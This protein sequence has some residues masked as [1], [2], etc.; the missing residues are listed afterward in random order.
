MTT[1]QITK[2]TKDIKKCSVTYCDIL[3]K[4]NS[5]KKN[6]PLMIK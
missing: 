4:A 2:Y 5:A 3:K 1:P 6:Y